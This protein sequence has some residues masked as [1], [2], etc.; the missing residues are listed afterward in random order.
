VSGSGTITDDGASDDDPALAHTEATT[1]RDARG[2]DALIG[3]TIGRYRVLARLGAGGMGVVYRAQDPALDRVVALKVLPTLA[4]KHRDDLEERLRREAQALARLD[5]ENVIRVH[6]VGVA[7]ESVFVAM[8]FVDGSTLDEHLAAE[9]RSPRQVLALLVAAGRGLAAAHA[10]GI[11]HR[12]FKPSNVLVDRN[13]R[14][15][16]GDFGLARDAELAEEEP[17]PVTPSLLS[18]GMTRHG[19][20]LGTPLYMAPEQHRGDPATTRSDQF[21]FC[22]SAWEALFGRHPFAQGRWNRN[23]ALRAMSANRVVESRRVR[24]VP[25]RVVRA[26]RRGLRHDPAARWP[27]MDPLLAELAPRSRAPWVL[28]GFA[29]AGIVGGGV[30]AITLGGALQSPRD[31]CAGATARLDGVWSPSRRAQLH[32][33]FAAT[34]VPYAVATATRVTAAIDGY[35]KGWAGMRIDACRAT[36]VRAEQSDELFDRRMACLDERLTALDGDLG[37]L[38]AKPSA[39]AVDG[40]ITMIASLPPIDACADA[41]HLLAQDPLPRDPGARAEL[42]RLSTAIARASSNLQGGMIAGVLE[43]AEQLVADARAA[44][45]PRLVARALQVV[46][47]ARRH[48]G[49]QQGAIAAL[50]ETAT[51][52]ARAHDDRIVAQ[53]QL[54]IAD[55]LQVQGKADDALLVLADADA[56]ITAAGDPAALRGFGETTRGNAL[57]VLSRFDDAQASYDHAIVLL[58]AGPD[59]DELDIAHT[60]ADEASMLHTALRFDRAR[61]LLTRTIAIYE[62][63]LG[64]GH[65]KLAQARSTLAGLLRDMGDLAGARRELEA[66]LAILRAR[67]QPD[68]PAIAAALHTLGIVELQD[69]NLDVAAQHFEEVY[70]RLSAA[71]PDHQD[72]YKA[73]YMLAVVRVQQGRYDEALSGYQ[74]VL[75]YRLRT[76]GEDSVQTANALDAIAQA[77][78]GKDDYP[79]AVASKRRGLAVREKLLGPNSVDVALSLQGLASLALDQGDCVEAVRQARR[80]LAIFAADPS[81]DPARRVDAVDALATCDARAGR[82]ASA[83]KR[84]EEV[85]ALADA[86]APLDTR[87]WARADLAGVLWELGDRR[88]AR[89]L[90]NESLAMWQEAGVDEEIAKVRRWIATHR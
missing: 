69:G 30:L 57:S 81:F 77:Y 54:V 90:A 53:A 48:G 8:Q 66:A 38:T 14:V 88:R 76:F 80:A 83:K 35:A 44:G 20:V 15:Y 45:S 85:L 10:A 61:E 28:G 22:V 12:D 3:S 18:S 32:A 60:L 34:G 39:D 41:P 5:H 2:D 86:S 33:G 51:A 26:L 31:A 78:Q 71:W 46:A 70:R 55:L 43:R 67:Y 87:A 62:R 74:R 50:R 23:A 56:A 27:S 65:P 17:A 16:V 40:A 7:A 24:G 72:T 47:E 11:V 64:T 4:D 82:W 9:P 79:N 68:N 63:R 37:V 84:Y 25:A 19:A 13:G 42:D 1:S 21:S 75:D 73:L 89:K 58:S 6:D 52:A 36:R 59:S 29:A 49:D